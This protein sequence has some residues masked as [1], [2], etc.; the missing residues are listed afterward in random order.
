MRCAD[1][2]KNDL[3]TMYEVREALAEA[4]M[5]EEHQKGP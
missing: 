3:N 1:L 4:S 2:W 5:F